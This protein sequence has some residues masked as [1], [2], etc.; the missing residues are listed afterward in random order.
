MNHFIQIL[1]VI[2]Y[3]SKY[4]KNI[5]HNLNMAKYIKIPEELSKYKEQIRETAKN[6]IRIE[7]ILEDSLKIWQSKIDGNIFSCLKSILPILM[8]IL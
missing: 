6:T 3:Q 4:L 5:S 8:E 7:L 2:Q 1:L